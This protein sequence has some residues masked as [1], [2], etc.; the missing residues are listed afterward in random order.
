LLGLVRAGI[1]GAVG[2]RLDPATALQ[3]SLV[4]GLWLIAPLLIAVAMVG[5]VGALVPALL[6][7]RGRAGG[8]PAVGLPRPP[9]RRAGQV[10]LGVFGATLLV[11][12]ILA[13]IGDLGVL[14]V[15]LMAGEPGAAWGIA[16]LVADGL[17][18]AGAVLV[19]A[20]LADL[21]LARARLFEALR[22][23]RGEQRL[24]QRAQGSDPA[25]AVEVRRLARRGLGR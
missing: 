17:G 15:A 20:G 23:S 22:V 1:G 19:L 7:R 2:G 25:V 18:A 5:A 12:L 13:G 8:R 14:L 6:A 9:R 10:L 11:C 21:A 24:E 3:R 16:D 4:D